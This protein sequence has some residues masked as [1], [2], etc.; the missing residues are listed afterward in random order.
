MGNGLQHHMLGMPGTAYI[1]GPDMADQLAD[2]LNATHLSVSPPQ[3]SNATSCMGPACMVTYSSSSGGVSV[4]P[5]NSAAAAA[6]AAG[7]RLF[8][9]PVASPASS[10]ELHAPNQH[11]VAVST[12]LGQSGNGVMPVTTTGLQYQVMAPGPVMVGPDGQTVY[13]MT[14]PQVS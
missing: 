8:A 1:S 3:G 4:S 7:Q 12:G 11:V 2:A 5:P 13:Y 9:S 14:P 10:A 6:I